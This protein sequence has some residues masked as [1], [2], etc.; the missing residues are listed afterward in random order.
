MFARQQTIDDAA[1]EQFKIFDPRQVFRIEDLGNAIC[2]RHETRREE[3]WRQQSRYA[4]FRVAFLM[5]SSTWSTIAF[6][7]LPEASALNVGTIRCRKT[8]KAIA[9]TSSVVV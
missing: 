1:G 2:G 5:S 3:L 4:A 7:S 6:S 8:G 9:L